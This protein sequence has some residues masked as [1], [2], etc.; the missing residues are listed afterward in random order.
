MK[1]ER[2]L[3]LLKS[4]PS[5]V[6]AIGMILSNYTDTAQR[7]DFYGNLKQKKVKTKNQNTS[8]KTPDNKNWKNLS[9]KKMRL[10]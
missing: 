4:E 2:L 6:D 1:K 8:L 10:L 9:M 5:K 3:E 7:Y